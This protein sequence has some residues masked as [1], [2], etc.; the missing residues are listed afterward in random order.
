MELYVFCYLLPAL[1]KVTHLVMAF[2]I[3][4]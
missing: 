2:Y 3:C 4:R 1:F